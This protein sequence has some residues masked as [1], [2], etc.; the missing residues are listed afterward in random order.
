MPS[1]SH[2]VNEIHYDERGKGRSLLFLHGLAA[3]KTQGE[4]ALDGLSG[5]RLIT[6]DMPGHGKSDLSADC[7]LDQQVGFNAYSDVAAALL[8]HLGIHSAIVGG[9]SMGAGIALHLALSQPKRVKALLL[10][11]PA[12]LDRPGRPQL[13]VIEDIGNWIVDG[14]TDAAVLQLIEHPV[15]KSA[16]RDN[17]AC[18]ASLIAAINRPQSKERATVLYRMVEDKPISAIGKLKK[19]TI[20]AL[21]VGNNA[22]PLHPAMIARE[23]C[24]AL[25]NARY[26]HAPPKYLEPDEHK[27]AVIKHIEQF[28][29]ECLPETDAQLTQ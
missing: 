18:A 2:N 21:V 13:T 4:Q 29:N 24:G 7:D 16:I 15:Y 23:I 3:D 14:G 9:I 19:C 11:R 27:T 22:D 28:L 20:P 8:E 10:I 1:F 26:F 25:A 12:W 6:V 17:P 5:Y